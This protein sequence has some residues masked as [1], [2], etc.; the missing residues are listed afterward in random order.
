MDFF[1]T[2]IL[3]K[4]FNKSFG[5]P[6]DLMTIAT[7]LF[8]GRE[9]LKYYRRIEE[10]N[11]KERSVYDRRNGHRVTL[12]RAPTPSEWREYDRRYANGESASA[13]FTDM[14]LR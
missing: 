14:G 10:S 4:V 13:I 12:R 7:L 2:D 11:L 9:F 6:G 8:L 5:K 3:R 1:D